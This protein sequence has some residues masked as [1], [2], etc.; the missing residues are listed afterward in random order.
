MGLVAAAAVGAVGAVGGGLIASGGAKSAAKT[1]AAAAADASAVQKDIYGQNKALLSPYVQQGLPATAAINSLLGLTQTPSPQ[2]YGSPQA[3]YQPANDYQP[4]ALAQFSGQDGSAFGNMGSRMTEDYS[5]LAPNAMGDMSSNGGG[6]LGGGNYAPQQPQAQSY[7]TAGTVGTQ[8]NPQSGFDM[9]RNSTGYNFRLNQ[10]MNAVNSG[11]AG[12]GMLQSGAAL[13][14]LNDYG[15]G[16]ASAE[17][18]NYLN[19]LGNQQAM[20]LSAAQATAGVGS[21]FANSLGNIAMQNGN[22]QANASL[23]GSRAMGNAVNGIGTSLGGIFGQQA[24]TNNAVTRLTTPTASGTLY[25]GGGTF[26]SLPGGYG[27]W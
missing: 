14:G 21:G 2:S 3:T 11:W 6:W 27:D 9:F 24:A 8:V 12:K 23:A 1:S 20:G 17:F 18:G 26:Q 22:N 10:G 7:P 4:N 16:M 15:Q 25:Q 5:Y 13:K 19:A